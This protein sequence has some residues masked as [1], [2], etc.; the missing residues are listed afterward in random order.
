MTIWKR[1]A[2]VALAAVV[3]T[4][5]A[6]GYYTYTFSQSSNSDT[7]QVRITVAGLGD[8]L[9]KV[10]LIAPPNI[11][12]FAMDQ[13]YALYVH[14]DLL[15]KWK[16]NPSE[17][18]GRQ[19]SS[20]W[21]DRID[22]TQVTKGKNGTYVATANIVEMANGA[23]GQEVVGTVPIKFTLSKGIDGWQITAYEKL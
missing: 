15:N 8:Q 7:A 10:P 5:A 14:P 6:Y 18:P 19:V 16:A 2:V 12:A 4:G 17:A 23:S 11:V 22:V 3:A 20:P 13:Y 1:Y 9:Q 21:P